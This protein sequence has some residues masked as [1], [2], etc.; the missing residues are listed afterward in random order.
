M[1]PK[2][3]KWLSKKSPN[4][5]LSSEQIELADAIFEVFERFPTMLDTQTGKTML[6]KLIDEFLDTRPLDVKTIRSRKRKA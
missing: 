3:V 2:F 1:L 4:L 5:D 6:F